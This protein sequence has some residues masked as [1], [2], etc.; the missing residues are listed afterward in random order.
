MWDLLRQ[1]GVFAYLAVFAGVLATLGSL[2]ALGA[3]FASRKL[4]WGIGLA[5]L[6]LTALTVF[7]GLWGYSSGRAAVEAAL[8][9]GGVSPASAVAIRATGYLE[10]Q[11]CPKIAAL[12][13][14][15]PLLLG[16]LATLLGGRPKQNATTAF[17]SSAPA[18]AAIV[19]VA[20]TA[21][22][23]LACGVVAILPA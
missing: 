18:I 5:S 9:G 17:A 6:L 13:V 11:A 20:L 10:A 22:G 3:L 1:G 21:L 2:A 23:A 12:F 7:F 19:V 8:I 16:G 4:A 15:A 14:L